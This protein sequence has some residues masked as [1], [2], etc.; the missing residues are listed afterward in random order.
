[1]RIPDELFL[2]ITT[3][4]PYENDEFL[5]LKKIR[6]KLIVDY[7]NMHNKCLRLGKVIDVI[8]FLTEDKHKAIKRCSK[9]EPHALI[10]DHFVVSIKEFQHKLK[11]ELM[12]SRYTYYILNLI[13]PNIVLAGGSIMK[14]LQA[15]CTNTDSYID[16]DF[17]LF[18][19]GN[20]QDMENAIHAFS[21]YTVER[22]LFTLT[23]IIER[24]KIQ[25]III[26]T[27]SS[28]EE[29][30]S[31]FD[32]DCCRFAYD[33]K[34]VYGMEVSTQRF[35]YGYNM[36]STRLTNCVRINKYIN[37]GFDTYFVDLIGQIYMQYKSGHF[38]K[39]TENYAICNA[40]S[41]N[42]SHQHTKEFHTYDQKQ[43]DD[44]VKIG[45]YL[46][47]LRSVYDVIDSGV[48]Y[49]IKGYYLTK[50]EVL[51]GVV[52]TTILC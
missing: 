3:F 48:D 28:I 21:E 44:N 10:E 7:F 22:T 25:L 13:G 38:T 15:P 42:G 46:E 49:Y 12:I 4:V 31:S 32:L 26:K 16:A 52:H 8:D 5:L 20:T 2:L 40:K 1:M 17:D 9:C 37:R 41:S 34:K 50:R 11:A 23:L 27:Y 35:L 14:L 6:P 36:C 24:V 39:I 51:N 45:S 29:L 18:V 33:G 30:I 43:I 47:M 19:I